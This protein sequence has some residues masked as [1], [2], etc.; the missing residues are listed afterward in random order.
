MASN[1]VF[2]KS[3][4]G[5]HRDDVMAYIAHI[6]AQHDTQVSQLRAD[7][8]SAQASAQEADALRQRIAELE[9]QLASWVE[10]ELAAY[11]RAESAE[12]RARERISQ[13][14]DLANGLTADASVRLEEA[15]AA[16][17]E[18]AKQAEE[19]VAALQAALQQSRGVLREVA[20]GISSLQNQE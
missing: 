15:N 3:I 17:E 13:M 10:A 6:N 12:R 1:Y 5:F 14:Y 18:L 9:A 19:S 2:R 7:L 4:S 20:S 16:L 11:R 8:L